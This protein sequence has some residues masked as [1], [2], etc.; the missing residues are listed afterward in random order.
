MLY[1]RSCAFKTR[2]LIGDRRDTDSWESRRQ[3]IQGVCVCV[4]LELEERRTADRGR[5]RRERDPIRRSVRG[6]MGTRP[7]HRAEKKEA[8]VAGSR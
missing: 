8:M 6:E 5:E 2:G 1:K 3:R 4:S 7:R